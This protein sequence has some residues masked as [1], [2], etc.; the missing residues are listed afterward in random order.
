MLCKAGVLWRVPGRPPRLARRSPARRTCYSPARGPG[1]PL[2]PLGRLDKD[3][4]QWGAAA[5]WLDGQARSVCC[6][7]AKGLVG[8]PCS[9]RR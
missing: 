2:V 3:G 4:P 9:E 5:A 7:Y 1:H 6:V 8:S